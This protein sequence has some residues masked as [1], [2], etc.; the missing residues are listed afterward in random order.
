M[1]SDAG[2]SSNAEP[3]RVYTV[4][5]AFQAEGEGEISVDEG[6]VV[7]ALP[8]GKSTIKSVSKECLRHN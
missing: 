6:H 7:V 8:R 4:Q 5:F 2:P 3:G 1:S